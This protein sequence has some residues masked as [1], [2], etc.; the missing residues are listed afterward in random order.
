[1]VWTKR[2]YNTPMDVKGQI[3]LIN[4]WIYDFAAHNLWLEPLG[5]LTI[6]A[7]LR[8]HGYGV[9]VIDCLAPFAGAPR[10]RP[11]GSGKFFRTI[12]DS[13]PAP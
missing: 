10:P 2:Q 4:P 7:A 12:I 1:V 9:R 6:A 13:P 11:D 3:L 8:D 5:L